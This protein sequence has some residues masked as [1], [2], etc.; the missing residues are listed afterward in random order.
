MADG[1]YTE[2]VKFWGGLAGLATFAFTVWDRAVRSRPWVEPYIVEGKR[3]LLDVLGIDAAVHLKI[4][5]PGDRAIGIKAVNFYH[6]G[7]PRFALAQ[8]VGREVHPKRLLPIAAGETCSFEVI[9]LDYPDNKNADLPVWVVIHWRPLAAVLPRLPLIMQTSSAAL[10]RLQEVV[11]Q[12]MQEE[13]EARK[14]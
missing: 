7:Q 4:H 5:N 1:I 9:W 2:A 10:T 6:R 8:D 13:D 14:K 12:R 11:L 3:P